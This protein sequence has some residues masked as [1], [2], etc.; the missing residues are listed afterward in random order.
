MYSEAFLSETREFLHELCHLWG[1]SPRTE[2]ALLNMSENVTFQAN[3]PERPDPVVLRVHRPAYHS[4]DEIESEL[5][6]IDALRAD[7]VVDTPAP[8]AAA[9]GERVVEFSHRGVPRHIVA[10]AYMEGREPDVSA[11]LV[12]GFVGLGAVSARLH[13]HV[14]RWRP[15]ASFRRKTWDFAT[16]L[17][18]RPHWGDWRTAQGLTA[19][20][21]AVLERACALLNRQLNKY[22]AGRDRFG[23]IHAD[24]RLANLL[25]HGDRI[26]VIDFDDCGF[27]WF[28]YD[29]AAAISFHELDPIVPALQDAW[30]RGYRTV[31]PLDEE[32]EAMLPIFV[33]LRRILL[34][35]WI[36]S[37]AE[38]PTAAEAGG[39]RYTDGTLDFAET[40]L[41]RAS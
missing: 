40:H 14:G 7:G 10:F 17:G 18:N 6:W 31:S 5:A 37:H 1:L 19:D 13:G 16:T 25:V 21:I 33:L 3:D 20:G 9:D 34:T 29:F 15:P 38:T 22:G 8:L 35:A 27:G 2:V 26:G 32:H 11:D 41:A 24:L 28:G 30:A 36:A 12:D 39:S 4:R 23:L